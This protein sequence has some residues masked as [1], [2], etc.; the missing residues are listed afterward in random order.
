MAGGMPETMDGGR[1]KRNGAGGHRLRKDTSCP[2]GGRLEKET[3]S[4]LR[5]KIVVP[6]GALMRQ[7]NQTLREFLS[8]SGA[9]KASTLGQK[10]DI[11]LK[12]GGQKSS[13]DHKYMI[14]V[15]N[16]ARYELARQILTELKRGERILLIADECHRYES[17]QN[18]LIFEFMPYIEPY[19][20]RFFSLGLSATLP[21]GEAGR[22]LSSVLGSRIYSYGIAKAAALHT[23]SKYDIYHIGLSFR[24]EERE[25]YEELTDRMTIAYGKLLKAFSYL[26]GLNQKELFEMLRSLAAGR[27]RKVAELAA[28]YMGLA[29]KRKR[30][31]CQ[32][33][34]RICCACDLIKRLPPGEKVIIFGE[35]VRQAQELYALLDRRYVGR[36]GQY[37]SRMGNQANRNT[38]ERFRSG[39][40]RILIACRALDEGLDVPDASV[41][42]ILSSTSTQRQRIQRLGRII[43]KNEEKDKASLYYLHVQETSEDACY[44][45]G[46]GENRILE[47]EY[48]PQT[49]EFYNE[50]Y[51]RA[52]AGLLEEMRFSGADEDKIREA[53][54]C[55]R[56]GSVRADWMAQTD[57][58]E[59]KIKGLER[60]KDRNY[61]VCMK[62]LRRF[63]EDETSH[64]ERN[65]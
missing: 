42:I 18:R 8:G 5:V 29:Y 47:L 49:G 3:G 41:G 20:D 50:S 12:G 6:T 27:D 22:F 51:E 30:L 62:R 56:L 64:P 17:G 57:D 33:G 15:I 37:H 24:R 36:A 46:G 11:G 65:K 19:A 23:V 21:G 34:T 38:L 58:I 44:L 2:D 59:E 61:W 52:A 63:A 4:G 55:L 40:I 16:S 25:E 14:Y 39:D 7:W 53:Q 32:A 45:P 31:V 48:L 9:Q 1:R 26:R 43:R 13:P 54:R 10:P 60:V 35:S 28:L